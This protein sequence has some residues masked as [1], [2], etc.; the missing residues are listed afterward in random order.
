MATHA[1]KMTVSVPRHLILFTDEV[2]KEMHV[3]RS[4]VVS[5]CLQQFAD[6]RLREEMEE[7][8]RLMAKEHARFAKMA[9]T[10]AH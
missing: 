10:I 1:G 3:S 9:A 6:E 7:G 4:K 8:Y 2:A 5:T